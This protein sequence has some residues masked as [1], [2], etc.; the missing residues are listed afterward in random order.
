MTDAKLKIVTSVDL[1]EAR[2]LLPNVIIT[3]PVQ[4]ENPYLVHLSL[5]PTDGM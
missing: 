1:D 5:R 2:S 3:Y 4:E